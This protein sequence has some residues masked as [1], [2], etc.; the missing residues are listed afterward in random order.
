MKW[1]GRYLQIFVGDGLLFI[2]ACCF[3]SSRNIYM[4]KKSLRNCTKQ[5][6]SKKNKYMVI[7]NGKKKKH[8][9]T[10]LLL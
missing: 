1:S 10:Q 6:N 9:V 7:K 5:A 8:S 2:T 3:F 4:K